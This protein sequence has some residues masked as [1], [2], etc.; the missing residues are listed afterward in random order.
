MKWEVWDY[1]TTDE[2]GQAQYLGEVTAPNF[3]AASATVKQK[4]PNAVTPYIFNEL[5]KGFVK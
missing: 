4:F 5:Q 3:T 1:G 2:S